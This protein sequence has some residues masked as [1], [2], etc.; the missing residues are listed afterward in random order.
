LEGSEHGVP[1]KFASHATIQRVP[2]PY[3]RF[4]LRSSGQQ[5]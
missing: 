4:P 5:I 1:V 2:G 3:P